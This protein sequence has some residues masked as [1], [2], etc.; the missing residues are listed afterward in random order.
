MTAAICKEEVVVAK[1]LAAND[2]VSMADLGPKGQPS[3][4]PYR[5]KDRQSHRPTDRLTNTR[6]TDTGRWTYSRC[7]D[8]Q[9]NSQTDRE[10]H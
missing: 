6:Q 2:G 5:Q 3:R 10:T 7:T 4:Q 8:I 9:T 1:S